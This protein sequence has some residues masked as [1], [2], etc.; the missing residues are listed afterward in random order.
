LV[1]ERFTERG[2]SELVVEQLHAIWPDAPVHCGLVDRAVLP[3]SLRDVDVRPSA[4]QRLYTRGSYGHLLPALA[5]AMA[6]TR[7]EDVDLVVMSHHAFS[8]RVKTPAGV[9]VVS[10]IHTPARWM[11]DRR[12]LANEVGGRAGRL[13]LRAFAATQRR[14]DRAAAQRVTEL[15]VNS[16]HVAG[17]VRRWWGREA[18]VIH[19]PVDLDWFTPGASSA[20]E[21]F[22]LL[23][24]RLVAYKQ[25]EVAIEAAA[26]AGVRLV[27]AGD[28]RL[29]AKV[30]ALAAPNVEVL[31]RVDDEALRDLYRRCRALVFPGEEDF[32]L[33]PV[34]AQACGAPVVALGVG[35]VLDS[36]VDGKTGT[37]YR[38]GVDD[39]AGALRS[40]DPARFD[41]DVI[42]AHA[43]GFG[44]A[45]FRD[46]FAALALRALERAPSARG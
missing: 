18:T 32:G 30:E 35:G 29:R 7:I 2:G 42:R 8:H 37:L 25:P 34:E 33:V 16:N 6:R 28:G 22:F 39:L 24:G 41:A 27:V 12:F 40:F 15:A 14:A 31:G 44:I 46:R 20:R 3:E 5:V 1:H 10:Y 13:G 38:G 45:A 26:R 21:D 36:V 11:W 4:A 19:P 43:E 9:P 17:R 23:A